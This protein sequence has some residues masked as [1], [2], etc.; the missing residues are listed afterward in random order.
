MDRLTALVAIAHLRL[1]LD[2]LKRHP[3]LLESAMTP[4]LQGVLQSFSLLKHNVEADAEK[5]ANRVQT[6]DSKRKQLFAGAHDTLGKLDSDMKDIEDFLGA[7]EGSNGGPLES[8]QA[9]SVDAGATSQDQPQ[10]ER[11]TV[12]GVSQS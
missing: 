7:I 5:L 2:I 9:S 10:P 12:N 11:L 8:S 6:A 1:R 4:K 3:H